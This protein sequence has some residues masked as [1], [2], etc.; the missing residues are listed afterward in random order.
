MS[1]TSK[2]EKQNEHAFTPTNHLTRTPPQQIS[3][4]AGPPAC[5]EKREINLKMKMMAEREER[6]NE[7]SNKRKKVKCKPNIS[8]IM[9]KMKNVIENLEKQHISDESQ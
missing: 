1:I 3:K 2:D 9:I 7:K 4:P 6:E 8:N 5:T